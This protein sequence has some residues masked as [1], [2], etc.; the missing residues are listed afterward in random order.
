MHHGRHQQV[1]HLLSYSVSITCHVEPEDLRKELN[2]QFKEKFPSIELPLSKIQRTKQDLIELGS[3]CALNVATIAMT[4]LHFDRLVLQE[5][6]DKENRKPIAAAC[7]VLS[8]KFDASYKPSST[9][10]YLKELFKAIDNKW[11][12]D[13]EDIL[14]YEMPVYAAL[15]FQLHVP[16]E[17]LLTYISRV[18]ARMPARP[19]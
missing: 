4:H 7:L 2:T 19:A 15:K 17:Q 3:Q 14:P 11:A 8:F 5:L 6:V 10:E 13:E 1:F 12:L 16:Q 9:K 18:E